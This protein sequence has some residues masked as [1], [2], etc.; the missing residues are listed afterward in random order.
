[1]TRLQSIPIWLAV[2]L[3]TGPAPHALGQI[4]PVT[5]IEIF[6]TQGDH[7]LNGR[8]VVATSAGPIIRQN[9]LYTLPFLT[10]SNPRQEWTIVIAGPVE[11]P[12]PLV[13]TSLSGPDIGRGSMPLGRNRLVSSNYASARTYPI[14]RV[15]RDGISC[16][17]H[18]RSA[19]FVHE[20]QADASGV[21]TSLAFDFVYVCY[22]FPVPGVPELVPLPPVYGAVR[23][24]STVPIVPRAF[25]I[26]DRE[27]A[28]LEGLP[29]LLDGLR[30]IGTRAP[31]VRYLWTQVS[32]PQMDMS[33]CGV[34]ECWTLAPKVPRGGATAVF[35]LTVEDA[36]GRVDTDR[37][38]L[39]IRNR[40]DRQSMIRLA[41][42]ARGYLFWR[43]VWYFS[44]YDGHFVVDNFNNPSPSDLLVQFDGYYRINNVMFQAWDAPT[45]P[46]TTRRYANLL[47]FPDGVNP[48]MRF[49]Y[50]SRTMTM[51]PTAAFTLNALERN[52]NNL[53]EIRALSVHAQLDEASGGF[54][55]D[56]AQIWIDYQPVDPPQV[57]LIG[58]AT[59]VP[60]AIVALQA[61]PGT[62]AEPLLYELFQAK[63]PTVTVVSKPSQSEW[64]LRIPATAQPGAVLR[65]GLEAEDS[66]GHTAAD[67]LAITITVAQTPGT[68]PPASSGGGGGSVHWAALLAL[69]AWRRLA[70][71]S[72]RVQ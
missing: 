64:N 23:Y 32:G 51:L 69:A 49:S 33:D 17:G 58:P 65:F 15:S 11:G 59:A 47:N 67:T 9:T 28:I 6:G 21:P 16:N 71:R 38:T 8:N 36:E 60:G 29:V 2:I 24:N 46:L 35:E 43:S 12:V 14:L 4:A 7:L 25:A 18:A 68:T 40:G 13:T 52:P 44:E 30:S 70:L 54:E 42:P 62:L 34:A 53:A 41:G 31:I 57:S 61:V 56:R 55:R 22:D 5:R 20:W 48:G 27:Q 3:L 26:A 66:K 19:V 1:M 72:G 63:G 50:Q 39:H 45:R 37:L 10:D